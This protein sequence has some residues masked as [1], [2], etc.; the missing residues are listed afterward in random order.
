[1]NFLRRFP[2]KLY[3]V[4]ISATCFTLILILISIPQHQQDIMELKQQM[5]QILMTSNYSGTFSLK[6]FD[7]ENRLTSAESF[8]NFG[9]EIAGEPF[10]SSYYG[11]KMRLL[12]KLDQGG[13]GFPGYMGVYIILMR[14]EHDGMLSWPFKKSCVFS[15]IDQE[16][17][18]QCRM[19]H[20][21]ALDPKGQIGFR[22]PQQDENTGLGCKQ[23][24]SHSKLR[25]RRYIKDNTVYIQVQIQQ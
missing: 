2:H 16:D 4:Q 14:S 11:Y 18:E 8:G 25:T 12:I 13:S 20:G 23:F 7:F 24:I 15:V 1:M 17:D 5:G 19:D 6:I 22:R 9:N 3:T 10:F 21:V